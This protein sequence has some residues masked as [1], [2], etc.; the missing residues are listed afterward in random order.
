MWPMKVRNPLQVIRA[1]V[2]TIRGLIGQDAQKQEVLEEILYGVDTLHRAVSDLLEYAR[3]VKL[4]YSDCSAHDIIE[5]SL[6]AVAQLSHHV[7]VHVELQQEDRM[8]RVDKDMFGSAFVNLLMNALEAMP[9][10]GD[11]YIRSTCQEEDGMRVLKLSISDTGCGIDEKDLEKI[12]L[13]FYTT[14]VHG[15]GLGLAASKK[16][17]EAHKGS[18]H[19]RSKVNEGTTVEITLPIQNS[20]TELKEL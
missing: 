14:K 18:L 9:N 8:I 19:I 1:G 3:P 20:N 12:E 7:R 4:Q 2:D 13:P 15:T 10:G 11:M 16:I 5:K 6:K 17:I